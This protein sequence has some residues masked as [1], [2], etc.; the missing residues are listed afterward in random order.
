MAEIYRI[1]V[2]GDLGNRWSDWLGGLDVQC[3]GDGTTELVGPIV[4][5]AALHGVIA[6]IRDLGVPLLGVDRV[7]ESHGSPREA[8]GE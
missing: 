2:Q 3:G 4:D 7:D 1:R 5:Q 6:R 8:T